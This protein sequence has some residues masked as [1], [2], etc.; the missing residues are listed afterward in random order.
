MGECL[1][2]QNINPGV[3]G[4]M[5]KRPAVEKGGMPVYQPAAA[6]YPPLMQFAQ[7]PYMPA[8]TRKLMHAH[9]SLLLSRT[10]DPGK[11]DTCTCILRYFMF[12]F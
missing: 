4:M 9:S 8:V 12:Y 10:V 5:V 1:F 2:M 11:L 7:P 6:A 3:P